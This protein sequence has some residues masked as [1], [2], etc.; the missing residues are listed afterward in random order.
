M[1]AQDPG[2]TKKAAQN[3]KVKLTVSNGAEQV[4]V[5]TDIVGKT[6]AAATA[7]LQGLGFVVTATPQADPTVPK[8]NVID[9]IPKPGT[10]AGK[11][12]NIVLLVSS[13]PQAVKVPPVKGLSQNDAGT[14]LTQAGFKTIHQAT[15]ASDVPAGN[16]TRT[17]PPEGSSVSPDTP[18][19]LFLSSGPPKV[20]VPPLNG[21]SQADAQTALTNAG[22]T[23]GSVTQQVNNALVGKVVSSNPSSGS[24]VAKGTPVD[25]VIGIA[26]G[27]GT[28][29][30]T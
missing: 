23:V 16:A 17:N 26:G 18:I 6:Q 24:S 12:A 25:L 13:G 5:P 4:L 19:T 8:N 10:Q 21:L 3:S 20:T 7:E 14:L 11:G 2:G 29:T 15:E 22:L 9:S 30:T 27:G 1:T 28:T